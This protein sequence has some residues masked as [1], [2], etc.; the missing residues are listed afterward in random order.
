MPNKC[1]FLSNKQNLINKTSPNLSKK[2]IE[3]N[4]KRFQFKLIKTDVGRATHF[5][6]RQEHEAIENTLSFDAAHT[7][8]QEFGNEAYQFLLNVLRGM[9]EGSVLTLSIKEAADKETGLSVAQNRTDTEGSSQPACS[10]LDA[11]FMAHVYD[12]IAK[13]IE[14]E[15]LTIDD[16]THECAMSRSQL[17][18]KIK[19]IANK[20][21]AQLIR[22][23]RLDTAYRLFQAD[24]TKRVSE[25]MFAVGF[26]DAQHF[27]QI[28][29]QRFGVPPQAMKR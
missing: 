2:M 21:P 23:Y 13:N 12:Y 20:T 11:S 15:D 22:D 8:Q 26:N 10:P 25:V 3:H 17:F 29:K 27:G 14:K 18:R 16:L 5:S 4:N 9:P 24:K 7:T 19:T 1:V 28:F 6:E